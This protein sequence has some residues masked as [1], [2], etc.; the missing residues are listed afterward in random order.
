[1]ERLEERLTG[2]ESQSLHICLE[3]CLLCA[4][5]DCLRGNRERKVFKGGRGLCQGW[6]A[7]IQGRSRRSSN[8]FRGNGLFRSSL[9]CERGQCVSDSLSEDPESANLTAIERHGPCL[10][11]VDRDR[12]ARD[13]AGFVT[14][15]PQNSI[16][17]L[18]R[19][20]QTLHRNKGV[21]P[22]RHPK[23]FRGALQ[24]DAY[25]GFHHLYG[26]GA[27]YEVACWAQQCQ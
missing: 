7:W 3:C 17:D 12:L 27:I 19:T 18:F 9:K 5:N 20:I 11:A 15:Q 8:S 4:C 21:H 23:E 1:M 13:V 10:A 14:E 16:R 2:G 24:A 25:A 26:D 22:R 6:T